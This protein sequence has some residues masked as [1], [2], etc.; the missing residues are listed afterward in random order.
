MMAA[1]CIGGTESD[2]NG[3]AI[4]PSP[5][6]PPLDS[7]EQD[8]A[9]NGE[10]VEQ[11]IGDHECNFRGGS[12][13]GASWRDSDLKRR[14]APRASILPHGRVVRP[15]RLANSPYAFTMAAP[16]DEVRVASPRG[17]DD[18]GVPKGGGD[19]LI[20]TPGDA[21]PQRVKNARKR[22]YGPL[23]EDGSAMS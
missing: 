12:R 16:R 5:K 23:L 22:A 10:Q 4:T 7:P 11:R 21:G 2:I 1:A 20:L 18:G 3:S 15:A 8:H 17:A 19:V 13:K 14:R 9:N 6:K